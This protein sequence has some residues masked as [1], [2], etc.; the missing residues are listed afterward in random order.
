MAI[1]SSPETMDITNGYIVSALDTLDDRMTRIFVRDYKSAERKAQVIL[2][3]MTRSGNVA[4][5]NVT[6]GEEQ[7]AWYAETDGR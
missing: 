7:V 5:L 1:A 3:T 2:D 4:I 6:N